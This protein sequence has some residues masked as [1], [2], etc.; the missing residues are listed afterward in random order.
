MIE[1]IQTALGNVLGEIITV[2]LGLIITGVSTYGAFR[3]KLL[4][5]KMKK[6]TLLSEINRY[7]EF[8]EKA[9]S[10]QL[11]SSDEKKETILEKAQ[12]FAL[13]NGIQISPS[14]LKLMVEGSMQSLKKL[15]GIGLKIMKMNKLQKG[16]DK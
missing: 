3:V 14:E 6:Q 15:E 8:A 16:E 9:K 2:V 4:T 10:F 12:E 11:M 1:I 13:E 7:V 5:D